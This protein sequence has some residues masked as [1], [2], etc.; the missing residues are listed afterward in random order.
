MR[1]LTGWLLHT[2]ASCTMYA[3][4]KSVLFLWSLIERSTILRV[5]LFPILLT[6][7]LIIAVIADY[8]GYKS[9]DLL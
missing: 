9:E 3:V 1:G 4:E 6:P 8:Y 2:I 5:I 7:V